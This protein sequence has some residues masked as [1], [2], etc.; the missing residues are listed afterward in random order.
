MLNDAGSICRAHRPLSLLR[1]CVLWGCVLASM[2]AAIAVP[3]GA[4]ANGRSPAYRPNILLFIS[5]DHG[6]PDHGFTG[7]PFVSTPNIDRLAREGIAFTNGY[8]A[9]P[10][11]I[12]SLRTLI[13]GV[14]HHVWEQL[15]DESVSIHGELGN[16]RESRYIPITLPRMLRTAGYT[17]FAGGKMWEGT[18]SDAGF[19]EG[20]M[21][22]ARA[23]N[24]DGADTFGRESLE[25][26]FDWISGQDGP[27]FAW[28]APQLPHA[29][30]DPG[31]DLI[32]LYEDVDIS[33]EARAYFANI[34]RMDRRLGE[35]LDHLY[36]D[37]TLDETLVIYLAD[38]GWEQLL[39]GST[40]YGNILGGIRGKL[41]SHDR[42]F[43][44]P[45]VLRWPVH[46]KAGRTSRRIV[47]FEDVYATILDFAGAETHDCTDGRS[48]RRL[49]RR[50]N[51]RWG[52]GYF[53]TVEE[54]RRIPFEQATPGRLPLAPVPARFLR[55]PH[56]AYMDFPA[57]DES[58]LF[59]L[60]MDPLALDDIG[61][62]EPRIVSRLRKRSNRA[63]FDFRTRSCSLDGLD[64]AH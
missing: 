13:S 60:R 35:I 54:N 7:H 29:P 3:A 5:D 31:N 59:D 34:S 23:L 4:T 19:D 62:D 21:R 38:N 43:H 30:Y 10:V 6:W 55:T 26:L 12:R 57:S 48:F 49:T 40:P 50:P 1:T 61:N 16:R 41:S 8:A 14:P 18:Y 24:V 45:V 33:D 37:G 15:V 27:W 36:R 58:Q 64:A 20:T 22:R 46:V 39:Q 32:A 42:A 52:R 53:F 63:E 9:A 56:H 44:T 25:P 51:G 47:D 11:C 17:S 28:V 2:H